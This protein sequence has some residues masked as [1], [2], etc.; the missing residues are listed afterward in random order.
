MEQHS[1]NYYRVR[2]AVRFVFGLAIC[3]TVTV[4]SHALVYFATKALGA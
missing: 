1:A 2:T 4:G 3:F